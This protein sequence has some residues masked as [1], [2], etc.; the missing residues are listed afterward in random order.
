MPWKIEISIEGVERPTWV[1]S[2]LPLHFSSGAI[3]TQNQLALIREL[4]FHLHDLSGYR[5]C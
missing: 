2:L 3:V 5:G 1:A 4:I